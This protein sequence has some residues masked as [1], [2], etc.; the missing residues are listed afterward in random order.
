MIKLIV[1]EKGT[2]KTRRF[3]NMAN[4][5]LKIS[6]GNVVCIEKGANTT[7][8]LKP[9]IRLINIDEYN[10][11]THNEL[12][13][14]IVGLLASN[15][16]ITDIFIDSVFKIVGNNL[17]ELCIL[18]NK[19]NNNHLAQNIDIIMVISEKAENLKNF[20]NFFI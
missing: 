9:Q 6:K 4:E 19:I 3:T 12:Y 2:G 16:D 11:K 1:G 7:F 10:I 5:T 13:G 8:Y 14:F 15:Y 20:E 18:I 17:D